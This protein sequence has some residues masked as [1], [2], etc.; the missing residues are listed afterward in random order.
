M[1]LASTKKYTKQDI[2]AIFSLPL[3]E[4]IYRAQTAHRQHHNPNEIQFCTLSSIKTGACPEDCNYCSQSARYDTGLKV[5]PL[6]PEEQILSEASAAKANGSTRFCMGAAWRSA[7]QGAQF[8][9]VVNVVSKV[10]DMGLEP[11]VTLGMITKEQ[12]IRLKDAGLH[13]YNHNIDT[14]PEYYSEIITT[15]KFEDRIETITNVQEAGIEVCCGG[16][17]GLGETHADR[18]SFLEVLANMDPQ[19]SSV[20]INVLV[21]I[22]GTPQYERLQE[23]HKALIEAQ[24]ITE[25]DNV[26]KFMSTKMQDI[27]FLIDK[28]ELVRSIATARILIPAARVRLSAGRLSMSEELQALCFVA[29]ANSIHTGA[30]L[31][32]TAN[33]GDTADHS[34]VEKLGMS[35]LN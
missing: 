34:L 14:S 12:A 9:Q 27:E 15:R 7:P 3:P 28:F 33:P 11:C 25:A 8:D 32:T 1:P 35:I 23:Q 21:P 5:E 22:E 18:I 4:L 30:K 17:L 2:E 31:L 13:S 6:I 29:G 24:G 10:R 19:P 20:P 26:A 16:I